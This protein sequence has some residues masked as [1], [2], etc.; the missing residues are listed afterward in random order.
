[1][2]KAR[3]S[4]KYEPKADDLKMPSFDEKMEDA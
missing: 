4:D 3:R 2:Y 1:M